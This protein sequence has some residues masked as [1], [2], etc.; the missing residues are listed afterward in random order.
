MIP[1][2]NGAGG[3]NL[4]LQ[5]Q[6]ATRIQPSEDFRATPLS[7]VPK[8]D[9]AKTGGFSGGIGLTNWFDVRP[10]YIDAKLP[11]DATRF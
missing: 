10:G 11:V 9:K 4:A 7:H 5:Y 2:N 1:E 6:E 8:I 3:G